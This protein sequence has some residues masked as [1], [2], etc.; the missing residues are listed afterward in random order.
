MGS[1]ISG[2]Q[3]EEGNL[4]VPLDWRGVN[5]KDEGEVEKRMGE[6][7]LSIHYM[8]LKKAGSEKSPLGP[9][10]FF[11]GGP[12][13]KCP[14]PRGINSCHPW[15]K[16]ALEVGFEVV[17]PDQRGVGDSSP[18]TASTLLKRGDGKAQGEYLKR[19]L[20]RS[21]VCD[22]EY[23]RI[24]K[25]RGE[26]WV[27]LG[28]SFGGFITL[29]YLSF[30]PEGIRLAFTSGGI[31]KIPS[32]I[33]E[34][35]RKTYEMVVEK[36]ERYFELFPKD[37]DLLFRLADRI[38]AEDWRLP[39]GDKMTVERL[40]SLGQQFGMSTGFADVHWILD[41][42]FCGGELSENFLRDVWNATSSYGHE[43]YWTLQ[44]AIYM[45][46]KG[47]LDWPSDRLRESSFPQFYPSARPLLFTG[48]MNYKWR[49]E[50][51]KALKPFKDAAFA[52]EESSEWEE[53]YSIPQLRENPVPLYAMVY[54]NDMY[55][56]RDDSM[57]TLSMVGNS[58]YIITSQFEHDGIRVADAFKKIL[59]LAAE[60]GDIDI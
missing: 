25:F 20:T 39:N 10:V 55:V 56:P 37:R 46:G 48:E 53:I 51:E 38:N 15:I 59:D 14:R 13:Q 7:K 40:Q 30:F 52:L 31:G 57:S 32:D 27:S 26:K 17:L 54:F 6:E 18:I 11:Q 49:F 36:N 42:A 22:F 3:I 44:E 9:L 23:L 45:D 33:M 47:K 29:T 19:F 41:E 50:E 2:I 24:K 35:Y 4:D 16:T 12:G 21:I 58:H 5:P 1:V 60:N 34:S 8:V 43:L 28:Q